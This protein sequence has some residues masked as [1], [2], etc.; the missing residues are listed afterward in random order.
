MAA[1][2]TQSRSQTPTT[3]VPITPTASDTIHASQFGPNGVSMR[4]KTAGTTTTVTVQDPN[5]TAMGNPA[6]VTG[7]PM[8]ATGEREFLIP[9]G[10]INPV[11]QQATVAFT[12]ALTGVTY[13]LYRV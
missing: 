3:P 11:S 7:A 4:V 6:T 5:T 1:V 8:P 12:G 9:R 2:V 13:E 10:A